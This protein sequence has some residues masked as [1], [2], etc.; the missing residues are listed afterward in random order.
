[1]CSIDPTR[2]LGTKLS[3]FYKYSGCRYES[4]KIY[5]VILIII[6]GHET[7]FDCFE[8]QFTTGKPLENL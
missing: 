4:V 1:M 6:E 8:Y 2:I 3:L 7:A 5:A